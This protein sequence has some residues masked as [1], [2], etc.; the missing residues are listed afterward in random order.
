MRALLIALAV[1]ALPTAAL[2]NMSGHM[3][4]HPGGFH[5]GFHG[6][7]FHHGF[8]GGFRN[9]GVFVAAPYYAADDCWQLVRTPYGLQRVWACEDY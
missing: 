2:A 5:G 1:A 8:H 3:G 6:G 9:F 7:G 4:G